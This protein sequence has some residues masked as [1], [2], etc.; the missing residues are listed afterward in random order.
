MRCLARRLCDAIICAAF[1][2]L[3]S[4]DASSK[5]ASDWTPPAKICSTDKS[6]CIAIAEKSLSEKSANGRIESEY[7]E[8]ED[9]TLVVSAKDKIVAEYP[10]YGY[11]LSAF[12]SPDGKY[13]AINNRRANAG[14]YLWVISLPDGKAIK[15]PD[16][17]APKPER[18]RLEKRAETVQA[19]ITKRFSQCTAD[20]LDKSWLEATGWK[21]AATLAVRESFK[22]IPNNKTFYVV[23]TELYHIAPNSFERL[24]PLEI[25]HVNEI[26]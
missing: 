25:K 16:D 11:L 12:W 20:E 19:Q 2:F 13:V 23:A 10:T 26:D 9:R 7:P 14:D 22:F 17:L 15:V 4:L 6:Y 21:D 24:P 8:S 18:E 5:N 3:F 1:L